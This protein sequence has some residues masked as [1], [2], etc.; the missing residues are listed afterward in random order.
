MLE[1]HGLGGGEATV[2]WR[3]CESLDCTSYYKRTLDRLLL[4]I[5]AVN[6]HNIVEFD[7]SR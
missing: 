3:R 4:E 5:G 2:A 1:T 7:L 6:V